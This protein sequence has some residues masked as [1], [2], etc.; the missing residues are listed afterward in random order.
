MSPPLLARGA[1]RACISV[2]YSH[3]IR[4]VSVDEGAQGQAALPR[5]SEVRH[6]NVPVSLCLP[7]A[8]VQQLTGSSY[9]FWCGRTRKWQ[10]WFE[11]SRLN[12]I[13]IEHGKTYKLFLA[14]T[15]HLL[16][17]N[18][19]ALV[20]Q[21]RAGGGCKVLSS[22]ASSSMLVPV[23]TSQWGSITHFTDVKEGK[24]ANE[25]LGEDAELAGNLWNVE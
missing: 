19:M 12:R 10:A 21:G 18:R 8:P 24:D 13:W 16:L 15:M 3:E 14:R 17:G 23:L 6:V 9:G 1:S 22:M 2:A 25:R 11:S 7:L 4:S 5:H 20:R